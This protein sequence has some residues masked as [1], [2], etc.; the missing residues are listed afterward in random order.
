MG[1]ATSQ[2]QLIFYTL[3]RNDLEFKIQTIHQTKVQLSS[4]MN[5]LVNIGTDMDPDSPTLK[6]LEQRKAKLK[7]VEQKLDAS[8]ARY[9]TQLKSVDTLIESTKQRVDAN[10]KSS[11]SYG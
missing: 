11:F 3:Y 4:S 1:L 5:D 10:I 2:L 8:L 7:L 6:R 9:Q